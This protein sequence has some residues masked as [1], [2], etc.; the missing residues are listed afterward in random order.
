MYLE[1]SRTGFLAIG[2]M[3]GVLLVLDLRGPKVIFREGTGMEGGKQ[4]KRR[5]LSGHS[6]EGS[7]KNGILSL[8]WVCCGVNDGA[9]PLRPNMH[10][11]LPLTSPIY[12]FI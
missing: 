2:Y 11:V 12:E 4:A 6:Q 5:S 9:Y 7:S 3:N 8:T 10:C 1:I